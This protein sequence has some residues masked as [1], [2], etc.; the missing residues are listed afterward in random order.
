MHSD[1]KQN[2]QKGCIFCE[3]KS[4]IILF[5]SENFIVA[6]DNFPLIEGHLLIFSKGHYGCAGEVPYEHLL[7]LVELK[8]KTS[9]ILA[10]TYSN[11]SFYE[12]GRAGSCVSFGPD[13]RLCHHFHLH[14]LPLPLSCDISI[15]LNRRFKQ[16]VNVPSYIAM[17]KLFQQFGEYLYFENNR[18]QAIFYP[19]AENIPSHLM[20]TLISEALNYPER[21]D[22]ENFNDQVFIKNSLALAQSKLKTI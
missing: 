7:E 4:H 16:Q 15:E 6:L 9:R 18:E 12:H 20:R 21:S 17:G 13:D 22:W 11:S 8:E 5:S 3:A 1:I 14:A 10:D 2:I 19:I